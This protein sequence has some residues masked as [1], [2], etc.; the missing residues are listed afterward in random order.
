MDPGSPTKP[1][2][3]LTDQ[4][5]A[6]FVVPPTVAVYD[7]ANPALTLA[8]N[9]ERLRVTGCVVMETVADADAAGALTLVAVTVAVPP[10]GADEGAM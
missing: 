9:G 4:L 2:T 10:A 8:L 1:D 7:C 5:T 3:P 6:V